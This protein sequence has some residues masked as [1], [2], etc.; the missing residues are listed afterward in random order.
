MEKEKNGNR[1]TADV[2]WLCN[3]I[4]NNSLMAS[5]GERFALKSRVY[6]GRI[7][8]DLVCV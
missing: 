8:V 7:I 3:L 4:S 6:M 1:E 2:F 5:N